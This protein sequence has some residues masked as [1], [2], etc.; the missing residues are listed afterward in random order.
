MTLCRNSKC[1]LHTR[2]INSTQIRSRISRK[3]FITHGR[4]MCD[5]PYIVYLIQCRRCGR[6][7][8]GQ[9]RKSLKARYATHLRNIKGTDSE[10]ALQDHFRR[11]VRQH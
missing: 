3:T 4:A 5:T 6:H 7:Y 2:L 8:M 11:R 9:T 10:G 1:P